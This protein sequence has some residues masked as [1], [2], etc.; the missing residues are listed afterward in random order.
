MEGFKSLA[1]QTIELGR[2]NVLIGANG[3]GKTALLEAMG[4]LGAAVSGRVD[5]GELMRRGVRPS[6]PQAFMT[7]LGKA[8][9]RKIR[10][11]AESFAGG[12]ETF[13]HPAFTRPPVFRGVAVP[14]VLLSGD[15][16]RI[17]AWR[18]DRSRE[19]GA[20]VINGGGET[21]QIGT[22]ER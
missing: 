4:L 5:A 7:A 1:R 3:S 22:G 14:D 8:P 9:A 20:R 6:A 2:L 17:A 15:H 11:E 18:R 10:L 19:L 21:L 13:D 12:A 16:A